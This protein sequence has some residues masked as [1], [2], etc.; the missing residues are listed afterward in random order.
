MGRFGSRSKRAGAMKGKFAFE[1]SQR[2]AGPGDFADWSFCLLDRQ[3][4]DA[5]DER[6]GV[7][8]KISGLGA[9]EAAV[10]GLAGFSSLGVGFCR[11]IRLLLPV[12]VILSF[13]NT[14]I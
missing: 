2:L 6:D 10:P 14:W 7:G 11:E 8:L 3:R 5:E 12:F 13:W 1:T 4:G 9:Q